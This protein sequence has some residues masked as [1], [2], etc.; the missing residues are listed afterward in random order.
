MN[1]PLAAS[2][3][4]LASAYHVLAQTRAETLWH[5]TPRPEQRLGAR[6]DRLPVRRAGDLARERAM[7]KAWE[8]LCWH[9]P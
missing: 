2:E 4:K 8:V 3:T 7:K 5:P 1:R 6:A 9:K